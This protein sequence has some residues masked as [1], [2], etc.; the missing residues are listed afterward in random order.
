MEAI[1]ICWLQSLKFSILITLSALVFTILVMVLSIHISQLSVIYTFLVLAPLLW[2]VHNDYKRFQSLGPGGT[3]STIF[4]YL[5]ITVLRLFALSDPY[6]LPISPNP[7]HTTR[8]Y[9]QCIQFNLPNRSGPRPQVAGIAPQRQLDQ[10]GC[11]RMYQT[12]RRSLACFALGYRDLLKTRTSC[13]EK[14]G[15]A[16]FA[17]NPIHAT[18]RGEICHVHHSDWSMHL[19]LH[20]DDAKVVLQKGWGQRHP[21][22]RGGWMSA[23]VP[24]E[25]VMIYAPRDWTEL[26][27]AYRIIEAATFWVSGELLEMKV[28]V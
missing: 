1:G 4:G 5:K 12:L 24:R 25:F 9:F 6:T 21:L 19:S 22:A 27:A 20:P 28:E 11:L 7:A 10:P 26:K 17:R 3:P 15:L 13:F 14:N 23:Y 2:V 8:G 16:L 18:C